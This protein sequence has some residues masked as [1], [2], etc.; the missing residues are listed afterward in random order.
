[1]TRYVLSDKYKPGSGIRRFRGR[2]IAL[3]LVRELHDSFPGGAITEEQLLAKFEAHIDELRGH[4]QQIADNWVNFLL[5]H[6]NDQGNWYEE[7]RP[8]REK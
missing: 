4:N 3:R 2:E 7:V 1:M 5:R 6:S 8:E